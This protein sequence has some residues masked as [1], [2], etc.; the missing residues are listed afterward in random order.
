MSAHS[1]ETPEG[2]SVLAT[3]GNT[4]SGT[5]GSIIS[6]TMVPLMGLLMVPLMGW[7]AAVTGDLGAH[8]AGNPSRGFGT[9]GIITGAEV[10]I[11]SS[12]LHPRWSSMGHDC[13]LVWREYRNRTR[14]MKIDPFRGRA[15]CVG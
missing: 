12:T 4:I 2:W 10:C 9:T 11:V 1:Y 8:E 6:G 14:G 7:P 3:I 5:S 13:K 15:V